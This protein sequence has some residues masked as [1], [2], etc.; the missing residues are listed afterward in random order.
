MTI[1]IYKLSFPGTDKVYIG[2][3]L[4]IESRYRQ[5]V[6]LMNSQESSAKLNYAF[7][8][9]GTPTLEILSTCTK[10][11][12]DSYENET[13]D[14]YNSVNSGFN[15]CVTAGGKTSLCGENH[16]NSV[17][18]NDQIIEVLHLLVTRLDLSIND[19]AVA[20]KVSKSAVLG[21]SCLQ[22]HTW[23]KE[24]C[25][26]EYTVLVDMHKANTRKLSSKS[27]TKIDSFQVISP[28]GETHLISNIMHF[29]KLHGL[30]KGHLSKLRT[31][32]RKTHK[33]WK[34]LS[35]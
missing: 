15:T 35:A 20:S 19:I 4:N 6:K 29:A 32:E 10:E 5:H 17:Y 1:G 28:I 26:E 13:I 16:P 7:L 3:S 24:G 30:D 9:L 23:L 34:L 21:I 11:E 18:P 12:L 31:G 2:Q 8:E 14:I 25:P 27:G 33:G 22:Y